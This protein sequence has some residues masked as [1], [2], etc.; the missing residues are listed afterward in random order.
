MAD[1]LESGSQ[2]L[3]SQRRQHMSRR[4]LYC[5]G[6]ASVEVLATVGRTEFEVDDGSGLLTRIESRDYLVTAA[7]LVLAGELVTPQ[8]GD[9]IRETLAGAIEVYEVMAPAG[10]PEAR[11]SDPYQTAWRIHTK[12]VDTETL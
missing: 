9:K 8:R 1:L 12:H 5:R 6:L 2:W 3:D 11:Y 10:S 4:V 7:D